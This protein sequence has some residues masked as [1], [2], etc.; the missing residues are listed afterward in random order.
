VLGQP[1]V[2]LLSVRH[3]SCETSGE[4]V[5]HS[6]IAMGPFFRFQMLAISGV[7]IFKNRGKARLPGFTFARVVW[8]P[9]RFGSLSLLGSHGGL[10]LVWVP[11]RSWRSW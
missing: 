7:S 9:R 10:S 5:T 2:A 8:G 6:Q 1:P 4:Q 11:W 3:L